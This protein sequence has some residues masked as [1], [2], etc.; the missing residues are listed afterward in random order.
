MVYPIHIF[1]TGSVYPH[2]LVLSWITTTS[3]PPEFVVYVLLEGLKVDFTS[4][5]L[6]S[7]IIGTDTGVEEFPLFFL[8]NKESIP[9]FDEDVFLLPFTVEEEAGF[10]VLD[11]Q[12]L[13][14]EIVVDLGAG[15]GVDT[16]GFEV[17]DPHERGAETGAEDLGDGVEIRGDG[18][19]ILGD[20]DG[21]E[22][23]G[24][25][26]LSFVKTKTTD[27]NNKLDAINLFIQFP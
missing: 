22:D 25:A 15:A 20:G 9:E 16:D 27:T 17:L 3:L 14:D 6:L 23:P 11:P 12:I 4:F 8:L 19:D 5:P 10:E 24:L 13:G 7:F 26:K 2:P 18:A 1:V 21:D